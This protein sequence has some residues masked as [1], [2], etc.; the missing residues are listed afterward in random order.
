MP[1]VFRLHRN[2]YYYLH[3]L[4]PQHRLR[5]SLTTMHTVFGF[6]THITFGVRAFAAAGPGME[7][8]T[9]KLP[10][11]RFRRSLKTFLFG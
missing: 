3:A 1:S 7:Q 5:L 11:S 6:T 10:Y 9:A 4:L 2:Y 8:F